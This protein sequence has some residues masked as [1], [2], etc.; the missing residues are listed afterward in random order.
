MSIQ[1]L[2]SSLTWRGIGPTGLCGRQVSRATNCGPKFSR[3]TSLGLAGLLVAFAVVGCSGS[4]ATG[5]PT[6][7]SPTASATP[8]PTPKSPFSRTGSMA[9]ARRGHTATLL[10]D[11]RVLIAG[12]VD[13]NLVGNASAELYNPKTGKFSPTG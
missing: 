13:T 11:G 7:G 8:A 10:S 2:T 1:T 12:G 5:S 3:A 6:A 9:T 4:S